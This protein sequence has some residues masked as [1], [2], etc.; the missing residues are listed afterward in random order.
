M[1]RIGIYPGSFDPVTNGHIDLI[2]RVLLIVDELIV[3]VART[4]A[5]EPLFSISERVAML[6]EAISDLPNVRV[7][8]LDELLVDYAKREK[9]QVIIRGVRAVSDFE[10]EFQMALM[11]R[12]LA[13]D[14]ETIFMM[15]D[16]RYSFLSSSIMKEVVSFGGSLCDLVPPVVE[17]RLREK[18]ASKNLT[19]PKKR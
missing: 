5:K 13:K 11:N 7:A 14:I 8:S 18:L 6:K 16:A 1:K 12:K 15:P 4:T 2:K 10:Y 9:A 17:K 3:A 19:K